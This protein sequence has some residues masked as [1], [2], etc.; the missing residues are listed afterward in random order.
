MNSETTD[1][2]LNQK[3]A[4]LDKDLEELELNLNE[5]RFRLQTV[6]CKLLLASDPT[7]SARIEARSF[8]ENQQNKMQTETD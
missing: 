8:V 6:H 3:V 7:L 1:E 5:M 2:Q 4:K